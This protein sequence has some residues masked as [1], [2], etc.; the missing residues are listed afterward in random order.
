MRKVVQQQ[1]M[2]FFTGTH[3]PFFFLGMTW[4]LAI[5]YQTVDN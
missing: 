1:V 4:C 3:F 2:W 5:L